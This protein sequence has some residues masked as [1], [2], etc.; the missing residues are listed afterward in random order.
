[1]RDCSC[2]SFQRNDVWFPAEWACVTHRWDQ[3]CSQQSLHPKNK[4]PRHLKNEA[5]ALTPSSSTVILKPPISQSHTHT[6][7]HQHHQHDL[8]SHQ[9]TLLWR[10]ERNRI[11][12]TPKV[13]VSLSGSWD[14]TIHFTPSRRVK[15]IFKCTR[16]RVRSNDVPDLTINNISDGERSRRYR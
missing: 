16:T 3:Y 10:G 12:C 5:G 11:Q 14:D 13:T 7:N 8:C 2:S 6:H 15:W 4:S 1:M 9:T